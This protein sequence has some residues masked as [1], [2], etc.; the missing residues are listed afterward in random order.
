MERKHSFVGANPLE[1]GRDGVRFRKVTLVKKD[2]HGLH[3][4]RICC[5]ATR[6]FTESS[7][8]LKTFVRL[9][10]RWDTAWRD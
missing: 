3:S 8:A 4:H 9:G 6:R 5:S 7:A 1:I 2:R 10:L